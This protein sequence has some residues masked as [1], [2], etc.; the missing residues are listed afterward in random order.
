MRVYTKSMSFIEVQFEVEG[1]WLIC[2]RE[3]TKVL[4]FAGRMASCN[5]IY[6]VWPNGEESAIFNSEQEQD[7]LFEYGWLPTQLEY[8]SINV[9]QA[10][11]THVGL[12]VEA[13]N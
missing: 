7:I 1:V 12:P 11:Y 3:V 4:E 5:C 9:L 2:N 10:F 13:R 6:H 8:P